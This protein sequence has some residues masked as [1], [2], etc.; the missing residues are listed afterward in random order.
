VDAS[1]SLL[2]LAFA[3]DF[4]TDP[5]TNGQ[6]TVHRYAGDPNTEAKWDASSHLWD[7]TLPTAT[8]RATAVF[9]N[10]DLT[11][12]DWKA[13]FQYRVGRLGGVNGGGDGFVFMFYKDA[14]GRPAFGTAMGFSLADYFSVAGYG[15]E[16]DNYDSGP[17]CDPT[18][19]D[20]I[21][22]IKDNTC[23]T[24]FAFRED[25]RTDDGLWHLLQ[26]RFRN[27]KIS[28]SI[29]G[30]TTWDYKLADPDCTFSG[31]GFSAGTGA[32]VSQQEITN[33]RL[34]VKPA[35]G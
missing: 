20:Y 19:N 24:A 2:S 31:I 30:E 6:W 10:Y 7:L 4:S 32:A 27:G 14:Y 22:L 5:N 17:E 15:L 11:A 21:A 3:D 9:A 1:D 35:G 12:T 29:D 28:L 25:D 26:F 16:F 8:Y 13:E 18:P 34:W 23:N 33:F